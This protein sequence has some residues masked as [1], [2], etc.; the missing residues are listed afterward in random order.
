MGQII[1]IDGLDGSGKETQS[2]ML[3]KFLES[4]GYNVRCISFPRYRDKSS[5][6]VK[7]YLQ[8]EIS[9]DIKNI[10]P[11]AA[12]VF[13]ACDRYIAFKTDLEEF[14]KDENAVLICDRYTSSNII[15]QGALFESKED[16]EDYY[17]WI[18]ETEF[19]KFGIPKW[20]LALL[21]LV[22]PKVS[23]NLLAHRN[24]NKDESSQSKL[25]II[26]ENNKLR[27]LTYERVKHA[28]DF[29]NW[30]ILDC[31]SETE[32]FTIAYIHNSIKKIVIDFLNERGVRAVNERGDQH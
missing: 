23:Q 18:E 5:T 7:M 21:L 16:R 22:N 6:L 32:M 24:N 20:N 3:E 15:H 9:D 31:S 8:K 4:E 17:K 12:S 11:Y 19:N 13:Y 2:Y 26:E 28:A 29:F 10:N 27:E 30:K 14:L 25:D 1:V